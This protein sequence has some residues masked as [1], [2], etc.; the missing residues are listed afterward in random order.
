MS[1]FQGKWK[2]G[3]MDFGDNRDKILH[4]AKFHKGERFIVE[5]L[6]PESRKQR[7]FYEGAVLPM[8]AFL[9]GNDHKDSNTVEQYHKYSNEEFNPEFKLIDGKSRNVGASSKGKLSGE[10]GIINKVIDHLEEHYGINR[11]EV[12]LPAQYKNW[13][14]TIYPYGGPDN[15]I[16]YLVSIGKLST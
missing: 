16:D 6:I 7:R 10:N 5:D 3:G 2:E 12:L 1:K 13:K 14:D 15:Y 9:D 8:W 4:H 11:E